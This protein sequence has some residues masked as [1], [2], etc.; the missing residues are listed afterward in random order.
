MS[1]RIA[2]CAFLVLWDCNAH[3]YLSPVPLQLPFHPHAASEIPAVVSSPSLLPHCPMSSVFMYQKPSPTMQYLLLS[4]AINPVKNVRDKGH[5]VTHL[6]I[7]TP[8]FLFLVVKVSLWC[9]PTPWQKCPSELLCWWQILLVF[10]HLRLSGF[11]FCV[12]EEFFTGS[13]ILG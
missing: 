10:L 11:K 12:F 1:I 6:T 7:F 13:R 4:A 5:S 8:P 3:T 2:F 9:P